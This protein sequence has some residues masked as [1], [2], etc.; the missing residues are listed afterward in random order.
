MK[1]RLLLR[2]KQLNYTDRT[3][4]AQDGSHAGA[5]EPSALGHQYRPPERLVPGLV[6]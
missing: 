1:G 5:W 3:G 4:D 6:A 2:G